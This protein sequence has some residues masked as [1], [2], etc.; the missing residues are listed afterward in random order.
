MKKPARLPKISDLT[1][2]QK[3]AQMLLVGFRGLEIKSDNPIINDLK[4]LQVGG[5]ILFDYDVVEKSYR[6][7]I[8]SPEQLM[9][10]M[11]QLYSH[12]QIPTIVS[13][14][15]EGGTVNRLKPENGFPETYSHKDLGARDDL[16]ET[17]THGEKIASIL[18][19]YGI[20]TNFAPCVDLGIN[21]ENKAIYLRNR[22]FSEDSD[23]VTNHARAYIRGHHKQ[24]VL[25]VLKHFPG[26]GSSLA[27]THLGMADVTET[28]SPDEMKPY[29]VLISEGMCDMVMSTHIFNG[30]LDDKY[31]ATL[32]EKIMK[33]MLREKL[34][35]EGVIISDD[36]QMQAI[37]DYFGVEK[38]IE[39]ALLA[40]ID[41]LAFG[42]NLVFEPDIAER[43]I[44]IIMNLIQKGV[45]DEERINKSVSR[46]FKLKQ[47]YL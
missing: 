12:I 9:E 24:G 35:F 43:S 7:N 44:A 27:D 2:E 33:G 32:S 14:D 6:R 41:I 34:G 28:W 17:E 42:N 15:Q 21:K 46:I 13:I 4:N 3:I 10:F 30:Q 20:N 26:H 38:V 39:L 8:T 18:K 1:L 37:T 19:E 29:E 40:D 45:I 11:T 31:P 47:K 23:K 25:T 16:S 36:L 22:T 5:I